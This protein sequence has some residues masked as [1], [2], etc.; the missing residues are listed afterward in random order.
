M[1]GY[2]TFQ[3]ALRANNLLRQEGRAN[4]GRNGRRGGVN[5]GLVNSAKSWS[6]SWGEDSPKTAALC[7]HG[8]AVIP[9]LLAKQLKPL[10]L[11]HQGLAQN[12]SS[13]REHQLDLSR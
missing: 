10:F 3:K 9:A 7:F 5:S 1:R 12:L 4:Q 6:G 8:A 2:T 13:T 11:V